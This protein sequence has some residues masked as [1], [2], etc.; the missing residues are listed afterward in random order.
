MCLCVFVC[1]CV[2]V[3][4]YVQ[5]V[6]VNFTITFMTAVCLQIWLRMPPPLLQT[7]EEIT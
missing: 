6:Q 5:C 4:M 7:R 2:C 1:V 3:C